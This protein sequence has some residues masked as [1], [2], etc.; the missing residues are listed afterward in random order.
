[1]RGAKTGAALILAGALFIGGAFLWNAKVSYEDD[2]ATQQAEKLL[3]AY[4]E[5]N[6]ARVEAAPLVIES[7]EG[8][9]PALTI[10]GYPVSGV[11]TIEGIDLELPVLSTWSYPQLKITACT[12]TGTAEDGG[13]VILAHNYRGHFGRLKN[14]GV[15]DTVSFTDV[16]GDAYIYEVAQTEVVD[17]YD[18][19]ALT[20]GDWDLTL[21]TCTY[22]GQSR[23]MVRCE[24]C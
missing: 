24:K 20:R 5:E 21:F 19:E 9:L 7:S 3:V 2:Q 18:L 14:V 8:E 17:Q 10:E 4:R 13:L 11:L 23:V 1:M 12:Y 22:G 15:G 6:A 16:N